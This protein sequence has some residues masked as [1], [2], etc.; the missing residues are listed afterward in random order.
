MKL[1]TQKVENDEKNKPLL[2]INNIKEKYYPEQISAM[3]LK[4]LKGK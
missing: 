4:Q 1:L 3:I 2:S